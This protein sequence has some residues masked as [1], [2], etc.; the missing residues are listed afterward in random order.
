MGFGKL[1]RIAGNKH[2]S[3]AA[4]PRTATVPVSNTGLLADVCLRA[5]R[6]AKADLKQLDS[7]KRRRSWK[8]WG[9]G[10]ECDIQAQRPTLQ[11]FARR[12]GQ[13]EQARN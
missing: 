7:I 4:A 10:P 12:G 1:A 5:E 13:A 9:Y 3:N 2:A 11:A 6:H 8:G